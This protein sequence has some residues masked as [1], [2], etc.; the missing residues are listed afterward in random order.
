MYVCVC[1]AVTERDIDNAV[2]EGCCSYRQL[3]EQLG[4]GS[5]CGRCAGCARQVLKNSLQPVTPPNPAELHFAL[6]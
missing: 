1:H 5:C 6:A 3:R 4:V 2:A